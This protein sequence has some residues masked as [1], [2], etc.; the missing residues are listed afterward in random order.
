MVFHR[1]IVYLYYLFEMFLQHHLAELFF[2]YY[3]EYTQLEK[4]D[5]PAHLEYT[6]KK[7]RQVIVHDLMNNIEQFHN[8]LTLVVLKHYIHHLEN[9]HQ[10]LY[11]HIL[12]LTHFYVKV[13]NN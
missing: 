10:N 13:D 7:D 5:T 6:G 11:N 8:L 9:Q 1:N 4:K 12:D 3:Q 2:R